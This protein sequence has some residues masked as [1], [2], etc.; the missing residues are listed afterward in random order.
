VVYARSFYRRVLA[1]PLLPD[2]SQ[3]SP[4]ITQ[5]VQVTLAVHSLPLVAWNLDNLEVGLARPQIDLRLNLEA[6]TVDIEEVE[7]PSPKG[8]VPITEIG[9][10]SLEELVDDLIQYAI[11]KAPQAGDIFAPAGLKKTRAFGHISPS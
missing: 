6:V 11:A 1:R 4:P 5:R 3:N 8:D 7:A 2:H 9:E 10:G